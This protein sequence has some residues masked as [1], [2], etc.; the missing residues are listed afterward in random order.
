MQEKGDRTMKRRRAWTTAVMLSCLIGIVF[1]STLSGAA[2]K[3]L[4]I[5]STSTSSSHYSYFVAIAKII[6]ESIPGVNATVVATGASIDNL[7]R[8]AKGQADLG[9]VTSDAGYMAY[10]SAASIGWIP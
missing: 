10:H 3:F 7:K 8:M 2:T 4:T 1:L 6:N 5:G 9:L